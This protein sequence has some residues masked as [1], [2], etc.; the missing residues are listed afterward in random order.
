[1]SMWTT[2]RITANLPI[3]S[4]TARR[5]Q[6]G[7]YFYDWANS[8]FYHHGDG[9]VRALYLHEPVAAADAQDRPGAQRSDPCPWTANGVES[10]GWSTATSTCWG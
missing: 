8:A 10:T 4:A 5:E 3:R 6:R 1:M 2:P 9:G 7:W